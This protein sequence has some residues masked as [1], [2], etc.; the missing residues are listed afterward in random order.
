M[1]RNFKENKPEV[2]E[3]SFVADTAEVIGKVTLEAD[4]SVWFGAVVRGD[5]NSIYIGKG[6]NIQD[7]S[8]VHA[9][10]K[11]TPT[12]VGEYVT[13]GHNVILHGCKIG[14]FSLIGMGSI[15]LDGA[16]IG[17]EVMIGA[18]SLVTANKKIPSGVLCMGSPAKVIRELTEE[19]RMSIREA[20]QH[21]IDEAKEYK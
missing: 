12:V 2:H 7:N 21:Y 17:E 5:S 10:I 4:A 8:T 14:N 3:S 18:G 20:A 11:G 16:E 1:I 15:I 9:N 6:S 19:E 13:V